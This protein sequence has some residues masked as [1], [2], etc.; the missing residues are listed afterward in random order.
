MK[1][2]MVTMSNNEEKVE[3]K[4]YLTKGYWLKMSMSSIT[5]CGIFISRGKKET[6]KRENK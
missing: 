6:I 4:K 5:D 3:A 1:K 2:I